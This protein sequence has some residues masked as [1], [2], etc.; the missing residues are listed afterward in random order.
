MRGYEGEGGKSKRRRKKPKTLKGQAVSQETERAS[1]QFIES[2][3]SQPNQ[4]N[5]SQLSRE[6]Y[7]TGPLNNE[8]HEQSVGRITPNPV[9]PQVESLSQYFQH[10]HHEHRHV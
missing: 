5:S 9:D 6:P 7:F 3:Q 1:Q 2:M 8:N 10:Q 4:P